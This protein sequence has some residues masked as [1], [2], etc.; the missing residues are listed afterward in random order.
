VACA[1]KPTFSKNEIR[2]F[3][4]SAIYLI[5]FSIVIF[6]FSYFCLIQ[7]WFLTLIKFWLMF[8]PIFVCPM[9]H[10]FVV[11]IL[12]T[13][14][15]YLYRIYFLFLKNY[16]DIFVPMGK[17]LYLVLV[18]G[19]GTIQ[20][21]VQLTWVNLFSMALPRG[22]TRIDWSLKENFVLCAS[23]GCL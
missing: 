12:C 19:T 14:Y 21:F 6:P 16:F 17:I 5:L 10:L 13:I 4:F 15:S 9:L 23:L 20:V 3:L 18:I 11:F 7:L 1:K 2:I 8:P 22:H